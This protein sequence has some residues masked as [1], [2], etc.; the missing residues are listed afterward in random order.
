MPTIR[1][2]DPGAAPDTCS[3]ERVLAF[4]LLTGKEAWLRRLQAVRAWRLDGWQMLPM[5]LLFSAF[6]GAVVG[7]ALVAFRGRDRNVPILRSVPGR[8]RVD[9]AHVGTADRRRLSFAHR[10][11]PLSPPRGAADAMTASE[12]FRI[13]LTGGIA[14]AV[15]VADLFAGSASG[16]RHRRHRASG[17]RARAAALAEIVTA[18]GRTCSTRTA[19][20]TASHARADLLRPARGSGSR[21]SCTP[22]FERRWSASR[23]SAD[24]PAHGDPVAREGRRRDHVD[25]VLVVDVPE[26]LQVERLMGRTSVTRA[27]PGFAPGAGHAGRT[28]RHRG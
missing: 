14:S 7:L 10:A 1:L 13:A 5:I 2:G 21:P 18:F 22:R 16:H 8:R 28:H 4:K 6:A 17:R 24:I 25:R 9:C 12:P 3:L 19:V 11:Q 27:G 20:S 26:E 23:A 15:H